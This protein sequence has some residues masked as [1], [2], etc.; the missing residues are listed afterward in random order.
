[1]LGSS[2]VGSRADWLKPVPAQPVNTNTNS[3]HHIYSSSTLHLLRCQ[4]YGH[5]NAGVSAHILLVLILLSRQPR[6][7]FRPLLSGIIVT[8]H[9]AFCGLAK[10]EVVLTTHQPCAAAC[11]AL[12]LSHA[13]ATAPPRCACRTV[14]TVRVEAR[15]PLALI[16]INCLPV[17]FPRLELEY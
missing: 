2:H 3:P 7:G 1:M 9:F 17:R 10:R 12:R 16:S 15:C 4:S 8:V 5:T 13:T 6:H 11:L 14:Q